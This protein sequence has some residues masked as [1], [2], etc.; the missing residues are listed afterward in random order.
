MILL[1]ILFTWYLWYLVF[2]DFVFSNDAIFVFCSDMYLASRILI[3][4]F[5]IIAGQTFDICSN[6][7]VSVI[8]L[9]IKHLRPYVLF[10]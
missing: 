8:C 7:C 5:Y 6:Y 10:F 4:F 2:D 9:N 3:F 1:M